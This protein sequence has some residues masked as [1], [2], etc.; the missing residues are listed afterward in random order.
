MANQRN[1]EWPAL[2]TLSSDVDPTPPARIPS[3]M[4]VPM[5]IAPSEIE[6]EIPSMSPPSIGALGWLRTKVSTAVALGIGLGVG[7]VLGVGGAFL[8]QRFVLPKR[9]FWN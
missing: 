6:M 5:E 2:D 4:S 1:E 8:L 7:A 3:A 9:S